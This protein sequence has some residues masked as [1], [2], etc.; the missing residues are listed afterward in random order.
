MSTPHKLPTYL[1]V[2]ECAEIAALSRTAIYKAIDR[3][4]LKVVLVG[5]KATPFVSPIQLAIFIKN[6]QSSK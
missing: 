3:N 2:I 5:K 1:T 6:R 4:R